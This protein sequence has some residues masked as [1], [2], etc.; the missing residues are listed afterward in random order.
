VN[1]IKRTSFILPVF[2][3]SFTVCFANAG[4]KYSETDPLQKLIRET[5]AII[6]PLDRIDSLMRLFTE[7]P[8]KK[9]WDKIRHLIKKAYRGPI[10]RLCQNDPSNK[11]EVINFVKTA[12]KEID[13]KYRKTP[14][15]IPV[16]IFEL[17]LVNL[18]LLNFYLELKLHL[19]EEY[20]NRNKGLLG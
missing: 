2:V 19:I 13:K 1:P 17:K 12:L 8:A 15:E 3:I 5:E 7:S 10:K 9:N 16:E 11:K 4:A 20:N 14:N 18:R 6:V